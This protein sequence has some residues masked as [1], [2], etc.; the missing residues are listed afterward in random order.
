[1]DPEVPEVVAMYLA[2]D[3]ALFRTQLRRDHPQLDQLLAAPETR[4]ALLRWLTA[5][6]RTA[7]EHDLLASILGHL[8]AGVEE[9]EADTIR[10]F[11]LHP[12]PVVRLRAYELLLTLYFPTENR[13]ALLALLQ[14]MLVDEDDGVRAAAARYVER[15]DAGPNLAAFLTGWLGAAEARGWSG[16]ESHRLVVR[17]AGGDQ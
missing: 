7:G 14:S 8:R 12:V 2:S 5:E 4:R 11:T 13:P 3:S 15:A 17:L 16:S 1:M 10:P 6:A 9:S